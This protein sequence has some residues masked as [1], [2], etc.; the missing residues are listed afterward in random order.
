MPSDQ[1]TIKLEGALSLAA[2]REA[3]W[4]KLFDPERLRAAV[5]GCQAVEQS[6]ENYY[7][8]RLQYKLGLMTLRLSG[9]MHITHKDPPAS[10]SLLARRQD[11]GSSFSQVE[12]TII[13][14]QLAA[15]TRLSYSADIKVSSK[16]ARL[17]SRW[18]QNSSQKYLERFFADLT[19]AELLPE[20]M[21]GHETTNDVY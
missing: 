14:Q 20:S 17:G 8:M 5:P 2:E 6:E 16:I 7:L 3:I 4:A 1:E 12:A 18:L 21:V 9:E 19:E 13:L 15:G 11:K 10:Y